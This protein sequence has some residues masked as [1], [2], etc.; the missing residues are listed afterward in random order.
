[1]LSP[2]KQPLASHTH[3]AVRLFSDIFV[4]PKRRITVWLSEIALS[5]ILCLS[6]PLCCRILGDVDFAMREKRL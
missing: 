1:M 4:I 3:G 5:I 2:L 6:F